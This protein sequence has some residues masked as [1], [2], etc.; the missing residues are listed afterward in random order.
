MA[1]GLP[2]PTRAAATRT[3]ARATVVKL[4]KWWHNGGGNVLSSLSLFIFIFLVRLTRWSRSSFVCLI[5]K[6]HVM[7]QTMHMSWS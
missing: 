5:H 4:G 3:K 1:G 6:C 2:P 7:T